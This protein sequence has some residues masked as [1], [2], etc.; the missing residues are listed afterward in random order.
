MRVLF[1]CL[2]TCVNNGDCSTW[3]TLAGTADV[4][5]AVGTGGS[6][7]AVS[8]WFRGAAAAERLTV[9]RMTS[10]HV[11]AVAAGGLEAAERAFSLLPRV[12]TISSRDVGGG[13][14]VRSIGLEGG[15]TASLRTFSTSTPSR[16]TIQLNVP[17][18]RE[19]KV[20]Y[21]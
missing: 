3:Q 1:A 12:G 2:G 20:R 8:G 11:D 7:T 14:M 9:T 18:A 13:V 4:A 15:G 6:G 5:L 19:I 17:G 21:E 16:P 10:T